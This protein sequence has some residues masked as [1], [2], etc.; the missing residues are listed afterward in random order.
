MNTTTK[1][2]LPPTRAKFPP[3]PPPLKQSS[4]APASRAS[5]PNLMALHAAYGNGAIARALSTRPTA[6]SGSRPAKAITDPPTNVGPGPIA[7]NGVDVP[8]PAEP[9]SA[10]SHAVP[11]TRSIASNANRRTSGRGTDV[12]SVQRTKESGRVNRTLGP[13]GHD[14]GQLD[15]AM[16]HQT[17]GVDSMANAAVRPAAAAPPEGATGQKPPAASLP[18]SAGGGRQT[19]AHPLPGRERRLEGRGPDLVLVRSPRPP[20]IDPH[21]KV[22][23]PVPHSGRPV[24]H[25]R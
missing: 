18:A 16:M 9:A 4:L 8:R 3:D 21:R 6:A 24:R 25:R 22:A 11:G 7:P 1:A 20:R 13:G 14:A 23:D 12:E 15:P 5:S 10:G 2:Q 17:A 19:G